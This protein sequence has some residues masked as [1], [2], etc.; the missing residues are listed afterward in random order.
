MGSHMIDLKRVHKAKDRAQSYLLSIPGVHAVGVGTK[1]VRGS[2]T[3]EPAIRVF[4]ERKK[5]PSEVFPT[6]LV[7]TEIDGF[8]TDVV[9]MPM[10]RLLVDFD[11]SRE[12]PLLGGTT[13]QPKGIREIGTLGCFG[14]TQEAQPKV[15]ALTCQHVVCPPVGFAKSTLTVTLPPGSP[16]PYVMSFTGSNTP[17]SIIFVALGSLTQNRGFAAYWSTAAGDT[18]GKVANGVVAAV[19]SIADSH[20][21]AA[22]APNPESVT[23]TTQAGFDT[24]VRQ[25]TIFDPLSLDTRPKLF[26]TVAGNTITF[27]GKVADD[28]G[29]YAMWNTDGSEPT[30]GCFAVI[31]KGS[32]VADVVKAVVKAVNDLNVAEFHANPS[33]DSVQIDGAQ[34]LQCDIIADNRVGQPSDDF[35]SNCSLC[36]TDELGRVVA[37]SPVSDVALVHVRRG[38]EYY[39]QVKGDDSVP[40][41]DTVLT[42]VH[43][44]DD[45]HYDVTKRG[46]VT[47]FS[48]GTLTDHNVSGIIHNESDTPPLW[49]VL[50]RI[51]GGAK[52]VQGEAGKIFA[53]PGDSGAAVLDSA[54]KVVGIL[55]GGDDTHGLVTPIDQIQTQFKVTILT[56]TAL[57]QKQTVTDAQGSLA[58]AGANRGLFD[59]TVREAQA[60]IAATPAGRRYAELISLH[61]PEIQGLVNTNQRVATVWHRNKGPK[62]AQAVYHFLHAREETLPQSIDDRPLADSLQNIQRVLVR[63]GSEALVTD[64][65]KYAPGLLQMTRMT[66]GQALEHLKT[67]EVF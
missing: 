62:I 29:V 64:L 55:F 59:P 40:V 48:K 30:N 54:G 15:V 16:N 67:K 45:L 21:F 4:L 35:S 19:N 32:S 37:S 27:R 52:I 34:Q 66:F 1:Q 31:P 9:Q 26:A 17:A 5:P 56:A 14:L 61:A 12:R 41:G 63:F 2:Y 28:Y 39:N 22:I 24:E 23:I 11:T 44:D 25:V 57:N 18:L 6:H 50:Y 8:K 43:T 46:A 13:I 3:D 60:E 36:C 7:P 33:G 42:G 53:K 65:S 20:V 49:S 51:Y 10:P 38:L 58:L 47:R